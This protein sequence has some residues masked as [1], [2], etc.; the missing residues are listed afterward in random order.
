M[1]FLQGYAEKLNVFLKRAKVLRCDKISE[2]CA[3]RTI[4]ASTLM[5]F[6][7]MQMVFSFKVLARYVEII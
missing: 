4:L 7:S 3:K 6:S 2:P 5:H 1:V